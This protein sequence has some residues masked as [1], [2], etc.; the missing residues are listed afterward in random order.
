MFLV[1][2]MPTNENNMFLVQDM[3]TNGIELNPK[4]DRSKHNK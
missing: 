3:P 2:G 4:I 1:Q